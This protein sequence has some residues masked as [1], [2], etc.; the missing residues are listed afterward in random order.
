MADDQGPLDPER[1][2]QLADKPCLF[3]RI[4]PIARRAIAVAVTR[5]V[6]GDDAVSTAEVVSDAGAKVQEAGAGAVNENNG[7]SGPCI[8]VVHA[9]FLD[10]GEIAYRR[11]SLLGLIR[12]DTGQEAKAGN[13]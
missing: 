2:H 7:R 9:K 8:R 4:W 6:D 11:V 3:G 12:A 10:L 5:P 13:Q 1:P